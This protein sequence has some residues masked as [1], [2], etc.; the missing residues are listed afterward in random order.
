MQSREMCPARQAQ[1]SPMAASPAEMPWPRPLTTHLLHPHYP[2]QKPAPS[3]ACA[4]AKSYFLKDKPGGG[5]QQGKKR[6]SRSEKQI[7]SCSHSTM[8]VWLGQHAGWPEPLRTGSTLSWSLS[9]KYS[10]RVEMAFL[11][12]GRQNGFNHLFWTCLP[13]LPKE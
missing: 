7:W 1:S 11:A 13:I 4:E 8:S 12:A 6:E 10:C 9:L 5:L 3:P 2:Q